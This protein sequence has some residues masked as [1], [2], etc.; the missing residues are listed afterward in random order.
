MLDHEILY[1]N[2]LPG[3]YILQIYRMSHFPGKY[4]KKYRRY[5]KIF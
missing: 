5:R 1:K 3:R 4:P 2:I